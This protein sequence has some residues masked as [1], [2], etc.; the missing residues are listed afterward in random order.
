MAVNLTASEPVRIES[1]KSYDMSYSVSWAPS[2]ESFEG[3]YNRYIDNDMRRHQVRWFGVIN[4]ALM[5]VF[6]CG[7]VALILLRT[8]RADFARYLRDDEEDGSGGGGSVL[9]KAMG[10][11]TGWKQVGGDVFRR[12]HSVV[13]YSALVGTGSHLFLLAIIVILAS[14]AGSLHVDRGAVL[15][16]GVL[17]YAFT[18]MVSGF[19]SG[20]FYRSLF[21]DNSS[22]QWIRVMLFSSILFPGICV[23][24]AVLL[25]I[26]A[27]GYGTS[28]YI[29]LWTILKI[30]LL[31]AVISAP[32]T[33]LGT[34]AGRRFG[35]LPFIGSGSSGPAFR[36]NQ[37]P[38]PVPVRPWYLSAAALSI[39]A[40]FLPFG[41][42][43]VEIYYVATSIWGHAIYAAWALFLMVLLILAMVVSC[44]S[45][46][47]T[48]LLLNAEGEYLVLL[49]K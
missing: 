14:L 21:A 35:H 20:A 39:A 17:A 22:P 49:V 36:V 25:S 3:R 46:V 44:V 5:A 41:S 27:L 38:R 34:I 47:S 1:G 4:S 24:M 29:S 40:G 37:I 30:A 11:E 13:L 16:A 6:L 2:Q 9:D 18:S 12:P 26:P 31:W 7:T 23:A 45:I 8:L 48:Y 19:F 28:S 10:D 43:F 42:V 32:L 15:R 33:V